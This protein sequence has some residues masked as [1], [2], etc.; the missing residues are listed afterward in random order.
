MELRKM[1]QQNTVYLFLLERDKWLNWNIEEKEWNR[2]AYRKKQEWPIVHAPDMLGNTYS[3]HS[4]D[5]W[6]YRSKTGRW[7]VGGSHSLPPSNHDKL[8]A[9]A[10]AQNI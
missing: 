8:V 2:S 6:G 3:I 10:H 5:E 1:V 7:P 9:I 4:G